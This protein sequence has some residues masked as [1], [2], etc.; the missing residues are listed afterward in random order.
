MFPHHENELA[1]SRCA[2]HSGR[3]AQVWMHNGFLQVEGAKMS[4]SLGNFVTIRELLEG[5][6]GYGW[7]GEAV[8]FNMLRSHYRQPLDW[9]LSGLDEAHKVLWDWYRDVSEV[10]PDK[11]VP[12]SVLEALADDL[13]TP[14]V[15]AELHG[16]RSRDKLGA[17]L[18][19]LQFLG[20]SGNHKRIG[21][22]VFLSATIRSTS[23]MRAN[24]TVEELLAARNAARKAK[25]F[26]ESDRIRDELAA[27]GVVLKD[28]KDGTTTWEVAR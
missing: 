8:R 20:F 5:W 19:A 27:M 7:P 24:L 3:M 2:F 16:L 11:E 17:L 23:Q 4:K 6:E 28:N 9:T 15:I 26:K 25:D 22:T 21:R 10:R 12:T 13:N 18:A 14:Q 1:Q